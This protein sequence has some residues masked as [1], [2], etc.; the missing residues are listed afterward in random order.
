[1][2]AR[3]TQS[4][5]A[6][7]AGVS[8]SL[9]SLVLQ[10]SPKVS[11]ERRELVLTA[12]R[13]L[14]YRPDAAAR[15]LGRTR[16]KTLGVMVQDLHYPFFADV[17]DGVQKAAEKL[18]LQVLINTGLRQPAVEAT[19]IETL[20]QFRMDGIVLISPLLDDRAIL[21]AATVSPIVL[22]GRTIDSHLVDS[23]HTDEP[24]GGLLATRHLIGLGHQRIL[25]VDTP[26][27]AQNSSSRGRRE[28]YWTAMT[29]A[30]L[31]EV[32]RRVYDTHH[33]DPREPDPTA[34][35]VPE[36]WLWDRQPPTAI[37]AYNDEAARRAA[38]RI[39]RRFRT[40]RLAIVG[41]DNTAL[42]S[43]G[44][45]P[46]SSI[47]Q[48]RFQMGETAVTM[49]DERLAGRTS[50]RHDTFEPTLVV[51]DTSIGVSDES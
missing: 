20:L 49:I 39:R 51:R 22:V 8:T 9:V 34:G 38:D 16:T 29:E 3:V 5:V 32:A 2:P 14:G 30:G 36:G 43:S 44:V 13:E 47:D 1:M 7:R 46:M 24:L 26:E 19:A 50:G 35:D 48:P 33:P 6:A 10:N 4:D 27:R 11:P 28:G 45:E 18:G 40:A 37:F 21:E 25:H 17:V 15:N 41:Y 23:V 31:A 42:A 12:I